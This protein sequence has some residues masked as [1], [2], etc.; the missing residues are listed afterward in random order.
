MLIEN[1]SKSDFEAHVLLIKN[2]NKASTKPSRTAS[3]T[4][5]PVIQQLQ[6]PQR[7]TYLQIEEEDVRDDHKSQTRLKNVRTI[8]GIGSQLI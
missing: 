1:T 8:T 6:P 4:S 3:L 5:L 7:S 2:K